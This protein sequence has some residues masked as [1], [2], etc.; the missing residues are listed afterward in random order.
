MIRGLGRGPA[1]LRLDMDAHSA[2]A[3]APHRKPRWGQGPADDGR[4]SHMTP[5]DRG[6]EELKRQLLQQQ[7]GAAANQLQELGLQH[8][9]VAAAAAAAAAASSALPAWR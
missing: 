3:A 4:H 9:V 6:V 8:A 1:R 5:A 7:V 2:A